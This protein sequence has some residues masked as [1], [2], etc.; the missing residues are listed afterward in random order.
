M[1]TTNPSQSLVRLA[2]PCHGISLAILCFNLSEVI[3]SSSDS[4]AH[5]RF[6]VRF[7][8]GSDPARYCLTRSEAQSKETSFPLFH[9]LF[10]NDTVL[11]CRVPL[12]V[13]LKICLLK[14]RNFAIV[15]TILAPISTQ[16]IQHPLVNPKTMM[17]FCLF[18][19]AVSMRYFSTMNL[20]T[21]GAHYLLDRITQGLL[22]IIGSLRLAALRSLLVKK[23]KPAGRAPVGRESAIQELHT[24]FE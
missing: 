22:R 15:I 11:L 13:R 19:V 17:N 20:D 3:R 12:P 24:A 6:Q 7:S 9:V 16:L 5:A 2:A 18:I 10:P 21:N 14:S 4:T 1:A 8:G 23:F